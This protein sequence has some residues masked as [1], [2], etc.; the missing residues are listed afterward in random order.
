[1]VFKGVCDKDSATELK[2]HTHTHR[3]RNR[4]SCLVNHSVL[5]TDKVKRTV[6]LCHAIGTSQ[7]PYNDLFWS[8]QETQT[9]RRF[10][11]THTRVNTHML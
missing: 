4:G 8:L 9:H 2:K 1:M 6:V 5:V 11:H 10:K 7:L 3:E